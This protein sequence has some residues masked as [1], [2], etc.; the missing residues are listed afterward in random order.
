ML[1][2]WS[3]LEAEVS[4]APRGEA[5]FSS[6]RGFKYK[7]KACR[8]TFAIADRLKL[9]GPGKLGA[10]HFSRQGKPTDKNFGGSVNGRFRD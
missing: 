6:D 1:G 10:V 9:S 2:T 4:I 3:V 8:N 7:V 5:L